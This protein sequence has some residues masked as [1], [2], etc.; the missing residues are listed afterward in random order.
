MSNGFNPMMLMLLTT[1]M[2]GQNKMNNPQR[3]ESNIHTPNQPDSFGRFEK[4]I[5]N[6]RSYSTAPLSDKQPDFSKI[7]DLGGNEVL[8]TLKI[9]TDKSIP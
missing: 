8:E 7:Q 9:L 5:D 3:S 6:E 1:M 4:T 2:N